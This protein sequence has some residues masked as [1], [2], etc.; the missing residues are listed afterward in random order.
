MNLSSDFV[1]AAT[2]IRLF[3]LDVDGTLTD[4]TLWYGPDGETLKA[5]HV[6]D[7]LGLRL[8]LEE[9]IEIAIITARRSEIVTKRMRDL[10]ITR[11][12]LGRDDKRAVLVELATLLGIGADEIAYMGDDVLDLPALRHAGL[13]IAPANAHPLV[14]R[15]VSLVV[16][17]DGGSGAVREATDAILAA[18][19]RLEVAVEALLARDLGQGRHE[20]V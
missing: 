4:G 15:E 13:S 8:L 12:Y 2:R 16:G 20:D 18:R 17:R 5:F 7:G 1:A 9:G 3:A 11:V 6:H 14:A 19:G 10:G